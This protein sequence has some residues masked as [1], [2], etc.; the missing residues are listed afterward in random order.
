MSRF[1]FGEGSLRLQAIGIENRRT[2]L[3][4]TN[5]WKFHRAR[6]SASEINPAW[7][8]LPGF[9]AGIDRCGFPSCRSRSNGNAISIARGCNAPAS[10]SLSRI[11]FSVAAIPDARMIIAISMSVFRSSQARASLYHNRVLTSARSLWTKDNRCAIDFSIVLSKLM[12][13][14]GK[15]VAFRSPQPSLGQRSGD[16]P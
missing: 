3:Y 10:G 6:P 14:P 9:S 1:R 5:L 2:F 15:I 12:N 4:V 16:Q 11:R 13:S 7:K 8:L